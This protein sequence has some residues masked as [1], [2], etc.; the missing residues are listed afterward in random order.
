M[1]TENPNNLSEAAP[2]DGLQE[3]ESV[4]TAQ[5]PA[6]SALPKKKK[7]N[8]LGSS[9][10]VETMFRT[11]YRVHMDLSSLADAKA[12]I[13]IS[14]NGIIISIIIASISP[15]IDTNPWLLLP[16]SVMLIACLISIVYAVLSA[17]P[18]ISSSAVD[19]ED[20]RSRRSNILFF[21]HYV[22]MPEEDYVEEMTELMTDQT[23]L[24]KNMIRDI[25]GLGQVLSTKFALLR[26]SYTAFMIGLVL[27]I[28]LFILVYIWVV[29]Y[30]DPES[31]S[32]LREVQSFLI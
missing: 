12:N 3:D 32:A 31:F 4:E 2:G 13:M 27:G 16:T 8:K 23:S 14:I 29:V 26:K 24:Y 30:M 28:V 20:F 17:R 18:R 5:D 7:K 11:S 9:R 19:L 21:G 15:K 22:S 1:T 10:G 25:Y 6:I